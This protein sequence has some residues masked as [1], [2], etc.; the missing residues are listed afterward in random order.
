MRLHAFVIVLC[1]GFAAA[2]A[3]AADIRIV[4]ADFIILNPTNTD[5]Q[6][7]DLVIHTIAIATGAKQSGALTSMRV[8]ILS[9]DQ[10][11]LTRL[12]SI[13]EM[14]GGTQYL[15][16][17]PLPGF[18]NGQVLNAKGVEGLFGRAVVFAASESMGPSQVL[19]AMRLHFSTGFKPDC[20]RVT[21][22]LAGLAGETITASIPVRS[23]VSPIQYRSPVEGQWLMQAIPGVLSHHRFNPATEFAVDFFKLG[24]D[25]HVSH[26]EPLDARNYYGFGAKVL[27]VA[28]GTVVSV[29][30]DQIQDR[31][32]LQRKPEETAASF[33]SRI[34]AYHVA[35]MRKNFRAAN[36]GNLITIRHEMDGAVEFSSYGHLKPGSVR[37]KAGDHVGRGDVIGEVGDT[38]DSAAVHLHFQLNTGSDAFT[39]KSLPASL[40]NL[41]PVDGNDEMGLLVTT[42][43]AH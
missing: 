25:G 40:A 39:S 10:V 6:Y 27:A 24:P 19:L 11:A 21:A 37:V 20:V 28:Q 12:I 5:K 36:A 16:H 33:A 30:T 26:G 13:D 38:G 15:A 31:A 7:S 29:I 34:D 22:I 14:V 23:Y 8:E 32:A 4:P 2:N 9:G 43:G 18:I 35:T 42:K 17:A 41:S 1:L 3:E